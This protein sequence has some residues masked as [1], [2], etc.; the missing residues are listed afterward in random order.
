MLEEIKFDY[1]ITEIDLSKG[2]QFNPSFRKISPLS[3]IPVIVDHKNN[4]TIFSIVRFGNVIGSRG[5]VFQ[6]F[7]NQIKNKKPLTVT[8]K[9]M[10]RFIMS[11]SEAG[12]SHSSSSA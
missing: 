6:I 12:S 10:T 8:D 3:K 4:K 11:I 5:S 2:E 9:R 7:Q 1:K